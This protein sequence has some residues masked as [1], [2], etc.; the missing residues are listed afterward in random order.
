MLASDTSHYRLRFTR[1]WEACTF[2]P[3]ASNAI[4]SGAELA[5]EEKVRRSNPLLMLVNPCVARP[6]NNV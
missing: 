1:G 4:A 5:G 3:A 6:S 2:C